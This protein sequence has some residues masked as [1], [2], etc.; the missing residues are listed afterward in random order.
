[1]EN[2][3]SKH[4]TNAPYISSQVFSGLLDITTG[5]IMQRLTLRAGRGNGL[6]VWR[7][8][9]QEWRNKRPIVM[10]AYRRAYEKSHQMQTKDAAEV[11][12]KLPA[13]EHNAT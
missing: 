1:M 10:E 7:L 12:Q 11:R 8:I 3:I 5:P 4:G 9:Y 6:E 13:W 2:A